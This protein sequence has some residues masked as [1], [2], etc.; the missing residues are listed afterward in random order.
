MKIR[1]ADP[2]ALTFLHAEQADHHRVQA[3]SEDLLRAEIR[4]GTRLYAHL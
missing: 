2:A 1:S 3:D 4:W